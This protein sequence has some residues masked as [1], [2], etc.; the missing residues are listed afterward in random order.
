[1]N[2]YFN[3][4]KS[5]ICVY[6]LTHVWVTAQ[7]QTKSQISQGPYKPA[8][9][10][11]CCPR[12]DPWETL[13]GYM[14]GSQI[15]LQKLLPPVLM[16]RKSSR[17]STGITLNMSCK[18]SSCSTWEFEF[19]SLR[20]LLTSILL[21]INVIFEQKKKRQKKLEHMSNCYMT[22]FICSVFLSRKCLRSRK[23]PIWSLTNWPLTTFALLR[24]REGYR[25]TETPSESAALAFMRKVHVRK[26]DVSFAH[27]INLAG[28]R[29]T[30]WKCHV[31][32]TVEPN[33][34]MR[35][36]PAF[37]LVFKIIRHIK[38]CVVLI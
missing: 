8:P 32:N 29:S 16:C 3:V 22:L 21:K 24:Q 11:P 1:M 9:C 18:R 30:H 28:L 26:P 37:A 4:I 25:R 12:I 13:I 27:H 23:V 36:A 17:P 33:T 19:F 7:A 10:S 35:F 20:R 2:F 15:H 31:C 34:A 5:L 38:T 6:N 14:S